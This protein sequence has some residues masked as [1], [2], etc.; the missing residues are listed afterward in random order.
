MERIEFTEDLKTGIAAIDEQH[1]QL[2]DIYHELITAM[3][4]H[5]GNRVMNEIL[6]RL[7]QYSKEH[8]ADEEALLK[9][10]AYDRIED[11]QDKHSELVKALRRY[12]L[13]HTRGGERITQEVVSFIGSWITDHILV[14]DMAY[15]DCLNNPAAKEKEPEPAR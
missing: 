10:H 1:K 9:E 2:V 15:V 7:F 11:H 12:I 4:A 13:R 14:E 5:H 8:F 6:A 3:E